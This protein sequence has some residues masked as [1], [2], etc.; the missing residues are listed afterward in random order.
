MVNADTVVNALYEKIAQGLF[1]IFAA[2]P[3]VKSHKL[4]EKS[5]G[6]KE[7]RLKA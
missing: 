4:W 3:K 5:H 1:V 7:P 2:A 6:V